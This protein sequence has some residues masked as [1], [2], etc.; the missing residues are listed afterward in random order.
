MILQHQISNHSPVSTS[1]ASDDVDDLVGVFE[2]VLTKMQSFNERDKCSL[3]PYEKNEYVGWY[4]AHI[5]KPTLWIPGKEI[6]NTL[7]LMCALVNFNE[8]SFDFADFFRAVM[9]QYSDSMFPQVSL[10]FLYMFGGV[11]HTRVSLIR[12]I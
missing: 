12:S 8:C 4:R 7:Y 1:D 9:L 10:F 2:A 5:S 3:M 11:L 6:V